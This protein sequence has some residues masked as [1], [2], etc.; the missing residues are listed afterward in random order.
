[1]TAKS[2]RI[3]WRPMARED[4]RAIVRYIGKDNPTWAK[5]FGLELRN[6]TKQLAQ[7]PELGRH[8]RPGLP[9]WLRELIVHP[10]YIV[11]YRVLC[12]ARTVQILRVK[13]AAQQTP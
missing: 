4:L 12:E 7:H 8:G 1:M 2:Y 13:H 5:S 11:F 9:E 3:E 10:N 6:K